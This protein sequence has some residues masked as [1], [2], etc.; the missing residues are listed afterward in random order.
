MER[1]LIIEDEPSI[2][3]LERDYLELNHYVADIAATGQEGLERLKTNA[4]RLVLLDLMLP[5]MDGYEVCRKIREVSEIPIIM[6]TAKNEDIDMIRGLGRGADDY[7]AKPFN[8]NQLIARVK[9]H[10]AR[11][12]RLTSSGPGKDEDIRIGDLLIQPGTRKVF[13]G[14]QEKILTAKEFDLLLFMAS[15]PNQ[16]F[17]KEHLLEQVW[18]FDFYGDVTTVTVH[19]RRLREKI[20]K[21]PSEPDYIDTVWGVGYRFKR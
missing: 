3:E 8:P 16:V 21:D 10:I 4:Y 7:I 1:I 5:D 12:D 17:S 14:N 6:V 11:Y 2:A 9:A 18:G 15:S 19:I 13:A 20:E